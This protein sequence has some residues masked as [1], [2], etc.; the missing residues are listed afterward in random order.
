M[1]LSMAGNKDAALRELQSAK[2]LKRQAA[3]HEGMIANMQMLQKSALDELNRQN[4][5]KKKGKAKDAKGKHGEGDGEG[6]D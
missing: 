2:V 1:R 4:A 6:D 5:A 3:Q